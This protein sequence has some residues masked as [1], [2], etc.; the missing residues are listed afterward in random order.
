MGG[1]ETGASEVG[2]GHDGTGPVAPGKG[3]RG[4]KSLTGTV[5]RASLSAPEPR[6]HRRMLRIRSPSANRYPRIPWS[7]GG[8]PVVIEVRAA[9]VVVG[10]TEVMGRSMPEAPM[11]VGANRARDRS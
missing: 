1:G 3:A 4:W 7:D 5:R 8:R 2:L 9:A 10:A 11:R 6:V